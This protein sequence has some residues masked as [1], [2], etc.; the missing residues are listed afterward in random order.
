[1]VYLAYVVLII[2]YYY[3]FQLNEF[4]IASAIVTTRERG[5]GE[6]LGFGQ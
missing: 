5:E 6:I 3:G 2:T 1:M 4:I